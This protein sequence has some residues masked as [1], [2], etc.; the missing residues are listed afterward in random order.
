MI[1]L[2]RPQAAARREHGPKVVRQPLIDPQQIRL[3]RLFVV[4]GS[5]ISRPAKLAIPGVNK[6]VRQQSAQR[7]PG[8]GQKQSSLGQ[9][10]VVRLVVFE[11]EMRYMIAEREQKMIVAIVASTKKFARLGHQIRHFLLIFGAHVQRICAVGRDVN[12]MM[13][14]FSWRGE[15]DAPVKLSGNYGR[16]HEQIE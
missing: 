7:I 3:H 5:Q 15:V 14:G 8:T 11:A 1:L 12:F 9:P 6:F 10:A 16:V 4:R 13:D 2:W